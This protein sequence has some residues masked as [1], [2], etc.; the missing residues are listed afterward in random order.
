MTKKIEWQCFGVKSRVDFGEHMLLFFQHCD[1]ISRYGS[2]II[3]IRKDA[4]YVER[5]ARAM[6]EWVK[7]V[8]A[9]K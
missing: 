7:V 2:K 3:Y 9:K 4:K 1:S 8:K 6:L 5:V